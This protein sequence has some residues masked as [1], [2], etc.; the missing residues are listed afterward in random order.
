[1]AK[2][3]SI[4]RR[5][6]NVILASSFLGVS[7]SAH[8]A[9]N[10]RL[11]LDFIPTG[12]YAPYYSALEH[13]I[14]ADHDISLSIVR[15]TGSGDTVLKVAGGA[16]DI[17]MSDISAVI[18]SRQR[19]NTPVKA[20]TAV[21]THSPHS[22]FV[23]KSSGIENF[24]GLEGKQIAVSAGNSH[25]LYFPFVAEQAN[26]DPD[27][28]EWVTVD[29]SSMASLLITGKVDA[30]PFFATNWYYQN[31]QAQKYGEEIVVLPF[32]EQGFNIYALTF[33]VTD[34]TLNKRTDMVERFMQ[35]TALAWQAAKDDPEKACAAHIKANPQVDMDDCMGN[36]TSSLKYIFNEFSDEHG[37]GLF[38][39]DRLKSTYKSVAEAQDL[40]PDWDVNQAID[41]R[42][43]R[44]IRASK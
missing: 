30:A 42:I 9:D 5:L 38:Q 2:N 28:I 31:K 17:G 12:D 10:V 43:I 36:L 11:M 20:I 19:S 15:G 39:A 27:K 35:A 26:T 14:Y 18:A 44:S 4:Y 8:A 29:G 24:T 41:D 25:K 32:S 34:D 1:M 16:A 6:R 37:V 40:D 13:G 21:Y 33:F 22:L 3:S 23:L 7:F